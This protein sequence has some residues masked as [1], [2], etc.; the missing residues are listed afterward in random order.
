MPCMEL[1]TN[2][3]TFYS[4]ARFLLFGEGQSTPSKWES[5]EKI[6]VFPNTKFIVRPEDFIWLELSLV[7]EVER[8]F[9]EC[10]GNHFEVM[11]VVNERDDTL[12]RKVFAREKAIID[13]LPHYGFHFGILT[14]MN[15]ALKDLVSDFDKP[16]Y[17]R[18]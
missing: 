17:V 8:V 6:E 12:R 7:P 11:T 2:A 18:H 10:R 16:A 4:N 9:V 14:R 5:F 15:Y 13:A 1:A 3:N